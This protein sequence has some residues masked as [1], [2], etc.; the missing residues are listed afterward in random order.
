[1]N[2]LFSQLQS[3]NDLRNMSDEDVY[4]DIVTR[5]HKGEKIHEE[6]IKF[7]IEMIKKKAGIK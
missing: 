3:W 6:D 2:D 4:V 5:F 7:M 1:M